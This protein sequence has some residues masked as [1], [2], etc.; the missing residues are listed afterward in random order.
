L[1]RI[2]IDLTAFAATRAALAQLDAKQG[3]AD[4]DIA[5]ATLALTTGIRSGADAQSMKALNARVAEAQ[6]ARSAILAERSVLTKRL[7]DLANRVV[8]GRDPSTL[9]ASLDGGHPIAMLPL[10]IETRY[11]TPKPGDPVRLRIRIYPDDIHTIDHEPTPTDTELQAGKTYWTA[12][13]AHDDEE[14]ARILRDLT[15]TYGRGR[16]TWLLRVLTPT[17]PIPAADARDVPQFPPTETIDTLA[18]STRAVLLPERFCAIGY[19]AGRREV[20]RV[21]GSTIPDELV[22]SPDWLA[23]DD[24]QALLGGDRAW[25]VDFDAAVAKGMAIEVTQ[26]QIVP[27]QGIARVPSFNLATG[28]LERLV[29]VGFEWT[30]SAADS[31]A[32][33]TDLLAAHRDST[34]LGFAALG[35]PTNNTETAP[36]GYSPSSEKVLPPPPPPGTSPED[37]DALQLLTW[38]FGIDPAALPADNIDNPHLTDQRT[39]LHMM[40]V[41]WRGTFGD[42]LLEMWNPYVN[43]KEVLDTSTLYALRR[44]AVSYLRPTGALPV[45]RTN[46]QPYGLLPLVGKRFVEDAGASTEAAIGKVLG[47]LRPMWELARA[48]VPLLVDGDIDKA[49]S[50]L[51]TA[52]WSQTAFYRDKDDKALCMEPTPFSG[53]QG[54]GRNPVIQNVLSAL[55]PWKY[56]DVHIGSCNDF[57]PDP[58]YSAG[59]LAGVPWVLADAKDPTKEASDDTSF[60]PANN[61]LAAIAT[62]SIQTPAAGKAQLDAYQSGPALLQALAAYSVQKEQGDAVDRFVVTSGAASQILSRAT[63]KMPYVETVLENEAMFT[64]QTPKELASVTIPALTGRATLGEH[65]ANTLTAQLPQG[66]PKTASWRAADGLFNIVGTVFPQTRDLGAV[67]LSLDFLST[68]SVGELNIAFRSTLDAFSYRLD[69]WITARAN[70]RLEQM[71]AAQP[72]GLY[73]GGYAWV[74]NLKADT[75]PD[76]EGYLLAPSQGQA[77]SAAILRSGFMANHEQGA[78]DIAL[79]S[80]RTRRALDI[81]QGLTRDQP[82]AALY[83]YRIERGLRDALLGKFIWPLRLAYPWKPGS[84]PATNEPADAIGARDVVDGTALLADWEIAPGNVIAKLAASLGS[85]NPPAAGPSGAEQQAI[86]LVVADALDLAD[87]VSDLLLAEGAHQIVQGNPTRAAAAMAVADKQSL[88]IET[89]VDRTPRG[90]AS[91]T[92][93]IC[94]ICPPPLPANGDLWPQDRRSRAEPAMNAWIASMLGDPANYRFVAHVYRTDPAGNESID[95]Q[96]IVVAADQLGVSALSA[97]LLAEGVAAPRLAGRAETGFRSV[98]ATALTAA[99]SDATNVTGLDIDTAAD[100]AGALGLAAFEAIAMTLKALLDKA[101]FATR[102]DLVH[103]DDKIEAT[104]PSLGEYSGVDVGEIVGRADAMVKE[105]DDAS[106]ALI[107]SAGADALLAALDAFAD[108]LPASAWPAQVFAIDASGADPLTRDAR[109]ADAVAALTP[110]LAAMHDALHSDPPLLPDQLAANN[111]QRAQD[112]IGR[113]KRLFGKDFPVLPRFSLGPYAT[114][115][116]ASLGNQAVLTTSD[117]WR[118]NGWLTQMARVREGA[119][120][121]AACVSAH[122]ALVS[123]LALG[124]LKVVQ[125]PHADKQIWAALPEAWVENEGTAFDPKQVPEELQAYLAAKPGT[126]YRDIQ[127]VAPALAI[128]LHAP[129]IGLID[130]A[131]TMASFVCDEWPEFVPDPFQTAAIGFHYDAPGARP[132]QTILLALPPQLGQAAWSF[133]DAVDVIHEA[134]DLARLRSVRPRDLASGLGALLPGNY[135]PH[136]YT[137]DLP[138]IRILEMQREARAK[139][140]VFLAQGVKSIPLGKI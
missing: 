66:A 112:A 68:R 23:T 57:L 104:Q 78:F 138:S 124:D 120:R 93:R 42:Y 51:Q 82:L 39:A 81:L 90:G 139:M 114:E 58:P 98:V 22:L 73:I 52:P 4:A 49:K 129:Q 53:V 94:V 69:A 109:A 92:Q 76:S 18:K 125:F 75:R 8:G 30:K 36:A 86:E 47:V 118:I 97:V 46:K 19:A 87:S 9:V 41:L 60:V 13:F 25:M 1:T 3:S 105:F 127:R 102:K 80:K 99:L 15:A 63:P 21:W 121:F 88:P 117:A 14:A 132:P 50:I 108:L 5:A 70:R 32:D 7:D 89:Q 137:D 56:Y 27:P 136:T 128:I 101:R 37:Q 24:P 77:A 65:V 134:F 54:S 83:G 11:V 91:Y 44:Y 6:K 84:A 61:Y 135:L 131:Q 111:A 2:D 17:N 28:T 29:V 85:M 43:G 62:A 10:R 103:V 106:T 67:K 74:E 95:A 72:G 123:P 100:R 31:A 116:N 133:D 126:P 45:L 38:A 55:G 34:G 113:L 20:F 33:F 110:I 115:F 107:A 48:N 26:A 16:A 96:P 12:R 40:N 79:D 59:Y 122:E 64:V 140:Q 35:T 130:A 71:R 119:D